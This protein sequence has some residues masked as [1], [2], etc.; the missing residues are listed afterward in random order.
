MLTVVC[1]RQLPL[2]WW[3]AA[4]AGEKSSKV[5]PERARPGYSTASSGEGCTMPCDGVSG[6]T[7]RRGAVVQLQGHL[8]VV[9]PDAP[10]RNASRFA[11][12]AEEV[13]PAG[14]RHVDGV[15]SAKGRH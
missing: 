9:R 13:R 4:K 7:C 11:V 10:P 14:D 6:V 2:R 3:V 8:F 1:S 12:R 5:A 15:S